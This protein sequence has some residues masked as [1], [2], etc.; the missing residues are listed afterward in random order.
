MQQEAGELLARSCGHGGTAGSPGGG[1]RSLGQQPH[2]GL[3]L[4]HPMWPVLM[5]RQD[6]TG[7]EAQR[8][9]CPRARASL[10]PAAGRQLKSGRLSCCLQLSQGPTTPAAVQPTCCKFARPRRPQGDPPPTSAGPA[11]P[12]AVMFYSA[13]VLSKRGPLGPIWIA[14][15]SQRGLKRADVFNCSLPAAVGEL[16]QGQTRR[17][18]TAPRRALTAA[19]AARQRNTP[20]ALA[21]I[22][23]HAA[24]SIINPEAPLALRLSGQLLL[25]LVRLY[26]RKLQF[27]EEDA[28]LALRGLARVRTLLLCCLPAG[29]LFHDCCCFPA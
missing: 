14:S 7:P 13:Q 15:W 11:G 5:A 19:A 2:L 4:S 3:L 28:G 29:A 23:P 27:L 25:G 6:S 1:R 17:P 20:T 22:L 21:P 9:A 8:G 18:G 16:G 10:P 12:R 24:D 26:L